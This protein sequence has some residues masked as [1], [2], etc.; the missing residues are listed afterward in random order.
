[1]FNLSQCVQVRDVRAVRGRVGVRVRVRVRVRCEVRAS[2]VRW[3]G[4]R[5]R[6][7]G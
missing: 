3:N 5:G 2:G 7:I 1:M 4:P 6:E